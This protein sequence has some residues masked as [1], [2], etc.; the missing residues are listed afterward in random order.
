MNNSIPPV[1]F[2]IFNRPQ[3][4]RQVFEEIRK[5]APRRL[6]VAADGP[7][8][9]VRSEKDQCDAARAIVDK[10]DWDCEVRTLFR[11]EN[12]GCKR[13]VA[14]AI[15]WF[16]D[17]EE[18]GIVLEDDCLP[19]PCFF[20]YCGELLQRY[21]DDHRV[22]TISGDNYQRG[23]W[24][25]EGSY[26]FSIFP[27]CWG[28]ATWKRA[29][30]LNDVTMSEWPDAKRTGWLRQIW[31]SPLD[32]RYWTTN[33]NDTYAGR[34]DTWDFGWT[35]SIWRSG[36]LNALPNVNLVENIGFGPDATHTTG[37]QL[38]AVRSQMPD[39][40]VHPAAVVRDMAADDFT[41]RRHF[42]VTPLTTVLRAVKREIE[43][44]YGLDFMRLVRSLQKPRRWKMR[45]RKKRPERKRNAKTTK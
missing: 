12:L 41:M 19:D 20:R 8:V 13:A 37:R 23:K 28:W 16:F 14:G 24:R 7:R 35:F 40:I 3:P 27:H 44:R 29:W 22:A 36:G 10:V 4:T 6:Y 38:N 31:D 18:E 43:H 15:D 30:R 26:Y 33:F 21:R 2:L 25:G 9:S 32:R 34:I 45:F 11:T 5:A 42:W 1:L 17:N 39:P